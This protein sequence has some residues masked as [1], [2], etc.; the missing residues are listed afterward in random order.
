MIKQ[1]EAT[2]KR[3][4]KK[5]KPESQPDNNNQSKSRKRFSSGSGSG[6][7]SGT[8]SGTSSSSGSGTILVFPYVLVRPEQIWITTGVGRQR[9]TKIVSTEEAMGQTMVTFMVE[10]T[11]FHPLSTVYT[12]PLRRF[13]IMFEIDKTLLQPNTSW[14]HSDVNRVVTLLPSIELNRVRYRLD[15]DATPGIR[16]LPINEFLYEYIYRGDNWRTFNLP[17]AT[18][19][20]SSGQSELHKEFMLKM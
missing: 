11:L 20:S 8:S 9:R 7:S 19:S 18:G 15:D 12:L 5:R 10:A 1:A 3:M 13:I 17:T 16:S 6:P 4:Q 2:L 14:R